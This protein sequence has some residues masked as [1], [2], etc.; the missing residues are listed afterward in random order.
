V[1]TWYHKHHVLGEPE[2]IM[3]ARL[4]LAKSA[5]IVIANGLSVLGISAP[6]RM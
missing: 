6:E 2:H 4:V 5:R 3:N 1:H